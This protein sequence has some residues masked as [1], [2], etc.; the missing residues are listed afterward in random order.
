LLPTDQISI[1]RNEAFY[2]ENESWGE[3]T[4]L[5]VYR[6]RDETEEEK[7][8]RL[9]QIEKKAKIAKQQRYERYLELKKEFDD[10]PSI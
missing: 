1:E 10:A 8:K 6:E 2:S 4:F 9:E 3:H 5:I 7:N